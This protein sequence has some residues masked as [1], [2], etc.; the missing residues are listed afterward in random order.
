MFSQKNN[1]N[2]TESSKRVLHPAALQ[3]FTVAH[4]Q[5]GAHEQTTAQLRSLV[6]R[7][8]LLYMLI[9]PLNYQFTLHYAMCSGVE[10]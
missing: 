7:L 3:S 4:D 1:L 9:I 5:Q 6:R 8:Q 10:C 2:Q